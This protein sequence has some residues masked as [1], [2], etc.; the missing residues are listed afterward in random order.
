MVV[1][2]AAANTSTGA[3]ETMEAAS[4]ELP[5]KL[6]VIVVPGWAASNRFASAGKT[7][8]RLAAASTVIEPESGREA[9]VRGRVAAGASLRAA[10]EREHG[11][12]RERDD[13]GRA[14]HRASS[15]R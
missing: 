7:P 13:A 8:F 10:G 14:R 11:Q 9:D 1:V 4:A 6:N 12:R 3:P 15:L 5:P 2:L